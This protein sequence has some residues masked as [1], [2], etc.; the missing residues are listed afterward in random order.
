MSTSTAPT[1][2]VEFAIAAEPQPAAAPQP[3]D[4][5]AATQHF[6][7][8]F[9]EM[10]VA[11]MAGMF[12]LA[13]VDGLILSAAGTSIPH[14]RNAAP[15]VVGIVMALNMTVGMT[16][17]MRHRRHSW[18]MCAEMAAAMIVPAILAIVLYWCAVIH[19]HS[20]A[21]VQ[22]AVMVPAM[23]AVMLLRRTAYSRSPSRNV[24]RRQSST[25][26]DPPPASFDRAHCQ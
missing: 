11:M 12:G 13:A 4:R 26:P 25:A 7:R 14:V 8:H 18:A 1:P 19:G 15:E 5:A 20:I 21:A 24:R 17:W 9:G 6:F 2:D 3:I 16:L 22:M 10:F 23:I